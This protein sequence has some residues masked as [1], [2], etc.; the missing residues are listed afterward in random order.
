M[1][2]LAGRT[3][4]QKHERTG[5]PRPPGRFG[6]TGRRSRRGS[7]ILRHE[8]A[9][10]LGSVSAEDD[11]SAARVSCVDQVNHVAGLELV[12]LRV[13]KTRPVGKARHPVRPAPA[14]AT[15][16]VDILGRRNVPRS[17]HADRE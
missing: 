11:R 4:V 12:D 13:Q 3:R 16:C 10:P 8:Y 9:G 1:P 17:F 5:E 15:G 7:R 14:I 6:N 2:A